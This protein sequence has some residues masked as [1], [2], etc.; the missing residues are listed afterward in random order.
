MQHS[1][2]EIRVLACDVIYYISQNIEDIPSVFLKTTISELL[3][4]SKDKNTSLKFAVEIA[5]A[6]LMKF[7]NDQSY[8]QVG[9]LQR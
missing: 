7:G 1:S 9:L 5:L 2:L 3:P 8:Y 4:I 6:S